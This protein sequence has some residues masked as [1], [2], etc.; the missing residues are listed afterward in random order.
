M[1]KHF[2]CSTCVCFINNPCVP[3]SACT[4]RGQFC[5]VAQQ[6]IPNR[7]ENKRG[8]PADSNQRGLTPSKNALISPSH[9]HTTSLVSM[10]AHILT[11]A[12]IVKD[13]VGSKDRGRWKYYVK[14]QA[15]FCV[16]RLIS[17]N[18]FKIENYNTQDL[19][20]LLGIKWHFCHCFR[21][22]WVTVLFHA[23]ACRVNLSLCKLI[24]LLFGAERLLQITHTQLKTKYCTYIIFNIMEKIPTM[25]DVW[26]I[27]LYSV[28]DK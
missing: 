9:I 5:S 11:M 15:S 19:L 8:Q 23:V 1:L 25:S 17:M 21:F 26:L 22:D 3:L 14:L 27:K 18:Y 24:S 7:G 13:S 28:F 16:T 6:H 12:S 4:H 10:G 20:F 2:P